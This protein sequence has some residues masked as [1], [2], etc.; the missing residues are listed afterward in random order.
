MSPESPIE[1]TTQTHVNRKFPEIRVQL[2]RD[3]QT[4]RDTRHYHGNEV[5]KITICRSGKLQGAEVDIVKCL[6]FN[7]ECFIRILHEL[8]NEKRSVIRLHIA[9]VDKMPN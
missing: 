3:A 4:S 6:V 5:V 9:V 7:A 1:R 2:T 8:V